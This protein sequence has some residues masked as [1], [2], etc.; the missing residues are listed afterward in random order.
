[1]CK[2][3]QASIKQAIALILEYKAVSDYDYSI[4]R[5]LQT[6][7]YF[8]NT[9]FH[10]KLASLYVINLFLHIKTQVY[11]GKY[12]ILKVKDGEG[13]RVNAFVF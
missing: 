8:E 4:F 13:N 9:I 2:K 7:L 5:L 3:R 11:S 6:L 1:M 10:N 12:H